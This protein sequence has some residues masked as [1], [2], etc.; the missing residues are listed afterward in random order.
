M[1]G[2]GLRRKPCLH[3]GVSNLR[4]FIQ[5]TRSYLKNSTDRERTQYAKVSA[6]DRLTEFLFYDTRGP[7]TRATSGPGR[8]RSR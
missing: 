2:G 3:P 6:P 7:G 5:G 4:G 8:R 1:I